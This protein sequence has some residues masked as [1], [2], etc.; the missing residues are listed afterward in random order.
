MFNNWHKKEKPVFTGVT[1]GLGG[2]GFGG[3]GGA[4]APNFQASGG[5]KQ[6]QISTPEGTF[7]VHT[8][9]SDGQFIIQSVDAQKQLDILMV[10]GG[11]PGN[12]NINTTKG[13]IGGGGGGGGVVLIKNRAGLCQA[14]TTYSVTVG[15][16][17]DNPIS[18]AGESSVAFGLTVGAGGAAGGQSVPGQAGGNFASGGGGGSNNTPNPP[19]IQG[20]AAGPVDFS[21]L[22]G[23]GGTTQSYGN[24]GGQGAGANASNHFGGGGG[25]AGGV[26][27]AAQAQAPGGSPWGFGGTGGPGQPINFDGTEYYYGAGGGGSIYVDQTGSS[28]P[29]SGVGAGGRGG[30]GGGGITSPTNHPTYFPSGNTQDARN[31]GLT[32]GHGFGGNA[33]ANT[34]AGGGGAPASPGS[35]AP[36]GIGGYGGSGIVQV[37]YPEVKGT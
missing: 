10:G 1:R 4:A 11:S 23:S 20:G 22:Q 6:T 27:G 37:R 19:G 30:G 3:G 26:G 15:D 7:T 21:P 35:Y 2:F 9:L 16:P 29:Q 18:T 32:G 25:G 5:T 33:G 36:P 24:A 8:F 34:G 14:A 12:T 13:I 31:A 17:T 28:Q